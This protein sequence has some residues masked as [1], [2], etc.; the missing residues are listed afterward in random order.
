MPEIILLC[1]DQM[2]NNFYVFSFVI[3][4]ISLFDVTFTPNNKRG[5]I[6]GN[7][8]TIVCRVNPEI[9]CSV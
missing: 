2:E 5:Y 9:F 4:N 3:N 1:S 6:M 7:I 8:L